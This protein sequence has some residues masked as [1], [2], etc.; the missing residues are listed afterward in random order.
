L[1]LTQLLKDAD[2]LDRVRVW[3][4]DV[5]YLRREASKQREDF[6]EYLY[7]RYQSEIGEST[8]PPFPQELVDMLSARQDARNKA[9]N[10]TPY[11]HR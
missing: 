7:A 5:N 6:A 3:D 10:R 9:R 1:R 11:F 4:L 2:G 8:T